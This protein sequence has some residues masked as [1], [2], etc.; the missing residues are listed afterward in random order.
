MLLSGG[1]TEFPTQL[2]ENFFVYF[3]AKNSYSDDPVSI[4]WKHE[5]PYEMLMFHPKMSGCEV[6]EECID[7]AL[8]V[9]PYVFL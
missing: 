1:D 8:L 7:S 6:L 5:N 4:C 9:L 2:L 3:V